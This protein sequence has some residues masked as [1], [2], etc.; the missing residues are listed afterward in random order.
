MDS[1]GSPGGDKPNQAFVFHHV[2]VGVFIE[3]FGGLTLI[4]FSQSF[5][6]SK[7]NRSSE[8]ASIVNLSFGYLGILG[9]P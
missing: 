4:T 8:V 6:G 1:G 5:Q 2:W 9:K 3:L 7:R